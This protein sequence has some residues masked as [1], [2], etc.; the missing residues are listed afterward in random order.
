MDNSKEGGASG[1]QH[2]YPGGLVT[3]YKGDQRP[4]LCQDKSNTPTGKLLIVSL[5]GEDR[6]GEGRGGEGR[7]MGEVRNPRSNWWMQN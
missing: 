2:S 3:I 5:G 6:R 4:G 7:R 1:R